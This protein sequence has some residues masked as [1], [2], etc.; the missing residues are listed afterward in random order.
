M[1][2][3]LIENNEKTCNIRFNGALIVGLAG[4]LLYSAEALLQSAEAFFTSLRNIVQSSF[5]QLVEVK[6]MG[7]RPVETR[8]GSCRSSAGRRGGNSP[9]R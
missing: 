7:G 3:D 5:G 2:R 4:L 8:E 1:W 9:N 6:A